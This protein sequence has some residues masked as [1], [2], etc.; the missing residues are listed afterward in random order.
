MLIFLWRAFWPIIMA[1]IF[2]GVVGG[3]SGAA[4]ITLINSVLSSKLE[5]AALL[6]RKKMPLFS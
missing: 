5:T 4:M 3:L 2:F 6:W 1:V